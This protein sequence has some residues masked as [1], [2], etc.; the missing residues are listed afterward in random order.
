M[1]PM[2]TTEEAVCPIIGIGAV[3]DIPAKEEFAVKF[4]QNPLAKTREG[5]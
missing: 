4:Y 5:A 2:L 1:R 3:M